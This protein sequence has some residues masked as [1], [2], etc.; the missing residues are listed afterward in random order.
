M[1]ETE[2]YSNYYL[3]WL[4]DPKDPAND[5]FTSELSSDFG[6]SLQVCEDEAFGLCFWR[7]PLSTA[8]IVDYQSRQV[9]RDL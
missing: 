9:V 4:N 5:A 6:S 7:A 1:T 8:Q 3:I 2:V